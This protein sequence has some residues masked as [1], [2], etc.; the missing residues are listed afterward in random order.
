MAGRVR[1]VTSMIRAALGT[2]SGRKTA[3]NVVALALLC[4]AFGLLTDRFLTLT[5]L[6]N[7]LRQISPVVVVGCAVT[8]LM[9]SGG[10]DLSVGAVVA[11]SGVSAALLSQI[12][13]L[14]A[15]F[16]IATLIGACVGLANAVLVLV[17]G[18]NSVIATLGMLYV[19]RGTALLLS[20]G[21]A[22]YQVPRDY[23][24]IGVG[25]IAGIPTPVV[26]MLLFVLTFLIVERGTILGRYAVAVGSNAGAAELAGVPV[27]LTRGILY[28]LAGASA[29][30][31]G[32]MVS[33]R[34]NSGLPATGQGFE[35]EVIVATILGGT[36]LLGGEGSI[37]GMVL[38]ALIVGLLGNGLNLL[39]VPTFWQTVAQGVVLVL[40]VGLD[41]TLRRGRLTVRHR[42]RRP[43]KVEAA[44]ES[45]GTSG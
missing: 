14:P 16:A 1:R 5:N 41:A 2:T 43:D 9:V 4:V 30:W 31:A 10:L 44:A 39:G 28:G 7:V 17:V 21:N 34:L 3:I 23:R 35:F 19:A 33:S 26:V 11:L 42:R 36:S 8:L 12:L 24:V 13:P 37:F 40:A 20:N 29:G 18:I 32:V 27:R 45:S 6:T 15:A 38:G 25:D 22:V